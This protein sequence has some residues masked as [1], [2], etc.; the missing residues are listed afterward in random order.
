MLDTTQFEQG[1]R[2][3]QQGFQ[4]LATGTQTAGRNVATLNQQFTA[5]VTP[6]KN[7]GNALT[8]LNTN[9]AANVKQTKLSLTSL[10]DHVLGMGIAVAGAIS[11]ATSFNDLRAAQIKN[12]KAQ[13]MAAAN[14]QKVIKIQEA[15]NKMQREGKTNTTAYAIKLNDLKIAQERAGV[16]GQR[17]EL[18]QDQYNETLANFATQIIPQAVSTAAGFTDVLQGMGV[19]ASSITGIFSKLGGGI[20]SAG[21]SLLGLGANAATTSTGLIATGTSGTIAATGLKGLGLSAITATGGLAGMIALAGPIAGLIRTIMVVKDIGPKVWENVLPTTDQ[22][23]RLK[24][25]PAILKGFSELPI[26]GGPAQLIDMLTGMT[27]ESD[28]LSK[29]LPLSTEA[30]KQFGESIKFIT[31]NVAKLSSTTAAVSKSFNLQ[32]SSMLT[33]HQAAN[34]YS[35]VLIDLNKN[36]FENQTTAGAVS[37]A[38]ANIP[39]GYKTSATFAQLFGDKTKLAADAMTKFNATH[40]SAITGMTAFEAAIQAGTDKFTEFI[41]TTELGAV[42]NKRYSDSLQ[43]WVTSQIQIPAG[44]K[45]TTS[46]LEALQTALAKSKVDMA[47]MSE[48]TKIL[49]DA[50]NEQLAPAMKTFNSAITADKFNEF[51]KAFKDM[52]GFGDFTKKARSELTGLIGDF[53]KVA[54]V[55]Q[56][57]G[58]DIS[59]AVLGA[60]EGLS[61]KGLGSF[62]KELNKDIKSI[63]KIDI[64]ATKFKPITDFLDSLTNKNRAAGILKI[65]DSLALMQDAMS[66]GNI[67]GA[68]AASVMAKFAEETGGTVAP[69]Q[70]S[71]AAVKAFGV[72]S[73]SARGQID[74]VTGAIDVL[75]SQAEA[76]KPVIK[77]DTSPALG[78]IGELKR[79]WDK[80]AGQIS[81]QI[82]KLN[83]NADQALGV[84][85]ETKRAWDKVAS[86]IQ[87]KV[88]K[89]TVNN[90]QALSSINQVASA[91]SKIKDKNVTVHVKTVSSG[92]TGG[93]GTTNLKALPDNTGMG[94][95]NHKDISVSGGGGGGGGGDTNVTVNVLGEKLIAKIKR[96]MGANRYVYGI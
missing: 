70:K 85:G 59:A 67:T 45:L 77:V 48:A 44:L 38:L 32:A 90:S 57:V 76:T 73:A 3:T 43:Q 26:T 75:K 7:Q 42:T 47:G 80:V 88:P 11:L 93:G 62:V 61:G 27:K 15:L 36:L 78:M 20:V 22:L 50:F 8:N 24:N 95:T 40:Q 17:A 37:K 89:I 86:Q 39:A 87:S 1:L 64:D 69:V 25:V 60:F 72:S 4:T 6:I 33:G 52:P 29:T 91:M 79:A 51:K 31:P 35:N 66:D 68:E 34:D 71:A 96:S 84:F 23:T 14:Q 21:A 41:S 2:R 94:V 63:A 49:A 12:D 54:K 92:G 9:L 74:A 58:T 65:K 30:A 16:A 83:A 81:K 56:E 10:K 55:A 13:L 18:V 5:G 28:K 82:P 19:K 53:R 46:Q